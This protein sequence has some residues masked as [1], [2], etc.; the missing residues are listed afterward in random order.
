MPMKLMKS[1]RPT[2]KYVVVDDKRKIH[3]GGVKDDGTP[4][5]DFLLMNDKTSKY[6]EPDKI[7]REKV[8]K[9]YRLRH[10]NDNLDNPYSSGAL[11]FFLLWN[12]NTLKKS[13]EDYEKIFNINIIIK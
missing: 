2:K 8:K 9:N 6:Y 13:I 12:K 11:S 1:K 3:F 10:K 7:I 5:R 4:Y